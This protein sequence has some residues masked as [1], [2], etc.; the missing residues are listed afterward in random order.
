MILYSNKEKTSNYVIPLPKLIV[1]DLLMASFIANFI[2]SKA[3]SMHMLNFGFDLLVY[4]A[5]ATSFDCIIL[6]SAQNILTIL[7]TTTKIMSSNFKKQQN[8]IKTIV[9]R[10]LNRG[11]KVVPILL[12]YLQQDFER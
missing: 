5:Y 8:E 11:I 4:I 1:R 10:K 7:Q 2:L 9:G 6:P 3:S 12:C